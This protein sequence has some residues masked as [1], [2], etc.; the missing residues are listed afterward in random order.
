[1]SKSRL[2]IRMISF[3]VFT[4]KR[5][6]NPLRKLDIANSG[7]PN[8]IDPEHMNMWK[9]YIKNSQIEDIQNPEWLVVKKAYDKLKATLP[10]RAEQ[11]LD[12]Q[13]LEYAKTIKRASAKGYRK[14]YER[15]GV[16]VFVDQD[17]VKGDFSPNSPNIRIVAR[18]VD[19]FLNEIK[20]ILP[21][22][23]PKIIISDL[24]R[25]KYTKGSIPND[26]AGLQYSKHI[27]IDEDYIN[28]PEFYVHEYAHQLANN[29]PNQ[30]ETL[31]IQAYKDMLDL[32]FR[33][34]KKRKIAPDEIDDN[35]RRKISQKLGFPIY[36]LTDPDELFAVIIQYWKRFPNNPI[37][38][39]FKSMVKN[40]LIRL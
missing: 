8:Y 38:Y 20:D 18:S 2:N 16:Q 32:Y 37:T 34:V 35:M 25:N 5:V 36:G 7:V 26:A 13:A 24:D 39:K 40:V 22:R 31:L 1:M 29:I 14:I 4:E 30:T 11:Y 3:K 17:N 23:K 6:S 27:F 19:I 10:P 12:Q 15:N 33:K 9:D 21:N 28:S